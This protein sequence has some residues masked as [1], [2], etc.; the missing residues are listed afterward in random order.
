MKTSLLT[1]ILIFLFGSSTLAQNIP[2]DSLYFG[3]T[4]PGNVPQIFAPGLGSKPGLKEAVI[5]FSP[6]ERWN[7]RPQLFR[8]AGKRPLHRL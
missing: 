6:M 5:T 4:P 1:P 7:C 3:Q 8:K 2:P